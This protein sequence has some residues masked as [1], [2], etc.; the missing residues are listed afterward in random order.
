MKP[1]HR[2]TGALPTM[3]PQPLSG[4]QTTR[5]VTTGPGAP[6]WL[7]WPTPALA[8]WLACAGF[9]ML[10]E[11]LGWSTLPAWAAAVTL[12]GGLALAGASR[13]ASTTRVALMAG[14]FPAA[15]VLQALAHQ[16]LVDAV[17]LPAWLWLAPLLVLLALYPLRAWRDAPLFPTEAG[18]L[19][20]LAQVIHLP[21][22][23]RVLDAGCGLGHGLRALRRAWPTAQLH[24]IEWSAPVAWLAAWRLRP[25]CVRRGDMWAQSWAG[26]DLVYLFQRPETMARAVA[27]ARAEMS[28]GSWLVSLEFEAHDARPYARLCTPAGK[29]VWIYRLPALAARP[30]LVP[31][32][33]RGTTQ[34]AAGRDTSLETAPKSHIAPAGE[35]SPELNKPI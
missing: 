8:G 33:E 32:Q 10:L 34:G 6:L 14:G 12:G 25:A 28:P 9:W 18:A 1:L 23:A 7:R 30:V 22:R 5:R 21:V 19:D 11:R 24:G 20:Q 17:Q 15:T 35:S 31:R 16:R 13:G 3:R 2:S 29:P 26:Y 27:K 4:G